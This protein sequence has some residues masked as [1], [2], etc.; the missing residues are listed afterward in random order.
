MGVIGISMNRDY[1]VLDKNKLKL[2]VKDADKMLD[3]KDIN[4]SIKFLTYDNITY[5]MV[6][7]GKTCG[8]IDKGN[9]YN[10]KIIYLNDILS[11]K[12]QSELLEFI[13]E[14]KIKAEMVELVG[15]NK[16]FLKV[17]KNLLIDLDTMK[18]LKYIS[19]D[20]KL[21]INNK[22][23]KR[24]IMPINDYDNKIYE[25]FKTE[26]KVFHR[27]DLFLSRF[28]MFIKFK[29]MTV[30]TC[31]NNYVVFSNVRKFYSFQ[32]NI[33]CIETNDDEIYIVDFEKMKVTE[34][35]YEE[36]IP[37]ELDNIELKNLPFNVYSACHKKYDYC[38]CLIKDNIIQLYETRNNK[39][40]YLK[41]IKKEMLK[42][43]I[44]FSD[45]D[46]NEFALIKDNNVFL[47]T[48]SIN[49][50]PMSYFV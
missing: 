11:L 19:Y 26:Q 49:N 41:D 36:V 40:K 43:E 45:T 28:T 8:I 17:N 1:W 39:I 13:T 5:L 25:D 38:L 46:S 37:Y 14:N 24:K 6:V 16:Y 22:L 47:G 4:E 29:D 10:K 2:Y 18:T 12:N 15:K 48:C 20:H 42:Y 7:D 32:R 44:A 3:I 23:E 34:P 27:H 31:Q 30:V 50:V 21:L 9:Y 33:A 35:I